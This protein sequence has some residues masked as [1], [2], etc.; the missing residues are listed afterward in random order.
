MALGRRL[1]GL[2]RGL[3]FCSFWYG[4]ICSG[5]LFLYCP[6]LPLL[7]LHQ[8]LFRQLTDIVFAAWEIYP[9]A[10]L[11]CIIGT[12]VVVTGDEILPH[13]RALII[14]NH[15]TR[16][17]WNFLWLGMFHACKPLTHR[18][19]MVLKASVRHIPGAGWV[20]QMNCFLYIHRRWERDKALL[21]RALDYFR[22]IGHSCQ[23]LLFPEG[24]DLTAGSRER[25]HQ[26]ASKHSLERYYQV[27]HPKTTGFVF[28]AQR[29]RQNGQL[30]AVYD[31]TVGYPRTRPQA[32]I[33][34]MKGNFPE[35]VH[36]TIT[37]FS[38]SSLPSGEE[39]LKDWLAN[40]WKI[41]EQILTKFYT[42][43]SF[44]ASSICN[45]EGS[46]VNVLNGSLPHSVKV[47]QP[48]KWITTRPVPGVYQKCRKEELV[49]LVKK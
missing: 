17:D 19:K 28:L 1:R 42:S 38:S 16:L 39:E 5:F 40:R 43:G 24:T 11:E 10:L 18:I 30:D 23:I 25:S 6:L 44:E 14:M 12:R 2:A 37:R 47:P 27:L 15:R 35:E 41:K 49:A 3:A 34:I 29:M 36:F 8:K 33:D 4:S 20:M 31:I 22:D 7:L 48:Q 9:A 13:D 26:F 45:K 46:S 21:E 32:E